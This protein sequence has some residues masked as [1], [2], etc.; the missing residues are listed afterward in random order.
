MG[1]DCQL[2]IARRPNGEIVRKRSDGSDF[3]VDDRE[4]WLL[5]R[6]GGIRRA[7]HFAFPKMVYRGIQ[8]P[9]GKAVYEER[10]VGSQGEWDREG[11]SWKASPTEALED[12]ERRQEGV[13]HESAEV[14]YAV[15]KMSERAREEY[16]TASA[17]DPNHVLDIQPKRRGRPRK[18][19]VAE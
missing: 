16:A 4:Y 19:P 2:P 8:G 5:E 1:P 14:A 10:I 7:E 11:A 12:Y 15:S 18:E 9:T 3:T 6:D 17:A 13:E